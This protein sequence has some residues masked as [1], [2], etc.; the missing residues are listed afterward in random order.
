MSD[1]TTTTKLSGPDN[2]AQ[3]A[4]QEQVIQ[5]LEDSPA[6]EEA[7]T[8]QLLEL[9]MKERMLVAFNEQTAEDFEKPMDTK[10]M[11]PA[12]FRYIAVPVKPGEVI[13]RTMR[14]P[15]STGKLRYEI[16]G[17]TKDIPWPIVEDGKSFIEVPD[18]VS[19]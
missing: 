7:H 16:D 14:F 13:S 19:V 10:N 5:L 6:E 9:D 15:L 11:R 4:E 12:R 18:G 2:Q 17:K 3:K 8:S 1:F